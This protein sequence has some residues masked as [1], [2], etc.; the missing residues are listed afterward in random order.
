MPQS[1]PEDAGNLASSYAVLCVTPFQN[2]HLMLRQIL[3][4]GWIVHHASTFCGAKNLL[5]A[6]SYLLVLC[7][8]EIPPYTWKDL[9]VE[10]TSLPD[11]PFFLVTA[12]NADDGLW[13]EALNWG[14]YDVLAKPFQNAEVVRAVNMSALHRNYR[15]PAPKPLA[16]SA[17]R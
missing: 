8:R 13:A 10:T 11:A 14:V 2:D 15:R 5:Q 12:T 7:E 17:A 3:S 9:F 4:G 1:K 16:R 6:N